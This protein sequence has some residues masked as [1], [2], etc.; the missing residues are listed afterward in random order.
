MGPEEGEELPTPPP[1]E[2]KA[3]R[4]SWLRAQ[5]TSVRR[6]ECGTQHSWSAVAGG[7]AGE[8][9]DNRQGPVTFTELLFTGAQTS[10]GQ[11]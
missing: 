11:T 5:H 4:A 9:R 8:K 1:T 7:M 2:K 3:R 6:E 10:L